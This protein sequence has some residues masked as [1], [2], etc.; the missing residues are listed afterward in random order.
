MEGGGYTKKAGL[1]IKILLNK[2]GEVKP[3]L[4]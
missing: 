2:P 1:S 4:E 3:G